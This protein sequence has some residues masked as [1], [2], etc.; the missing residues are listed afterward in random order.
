MF[1]DLD[2]YFSNLNTNQCPPPWQLALALD[3]LQVLMP[4]LISG[5]TTTSNISHNGHDVTSTHLDI[6]KLM[7][8]VYSRSG[9]NPFHSK[10]AKVVSV[11]TRLTFNSS[12]T[13]MSSVR[14]AFMTA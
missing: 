4:A 11:F 1:V 2:C 5:D 13:E 7:P 3:P 10:S 12:E 9:G 6:G 8:S 14:L